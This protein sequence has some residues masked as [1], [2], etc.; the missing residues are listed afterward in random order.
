M[1]RTWGLA[2]AIALS[3]IALQF[4]LHQIPFGGDAWVASLFVLGFAGAIAIGVAMGRFDVAGS[5][6]WLDAPAVG[7]VAAAILSVAIALMQWTWTDS[8]PLP[9]NF[10]ARGDRPYANF[11]QANNFCTALFLGLCALCWLREAGRIGPLG[12]L[13]GS[14]FLLFGMT[15]SGS[16]TG[17]LQMLAA[18]ALLCWAGRR[19]DR[20]LVRVP[21]ALALLVSFIVM[22]LAWPAFNDMLLLSGGRTASDQV[23]AGLRLP[24]WQMV[25]DAISRQ[26]LQG[27][28]WLQNSSA[29]WA[30][31]LDHSHLQR[32][33][34]YSHSLLLDLLIW[35]GLPLGGLIA[36][37]VGWGLYRQSRAINDARA[38]WLF[39]GVLGFFVHALLE[40]PHAYAYLLLPVGVSIGMVHTLCPG[41]ASLRLRPAPLALAWIVMLAAAMV[42]AT[43]YLKV[44]QNY[45][46]ARLESAFGERRIVTPAPDLQVLS[47]LGAF[48]QLIRTEAR[49]GMST[50]E[51]AA[52]HKVVVRYPHPPALLRL[53]LAQGLNDR[54]GDARDTLRRLCAMHL[55]ARCEET[56]ASWHVLQLQHPILQAIELPALPR[57]R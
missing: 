10:L 50:D 44:E 21:H 17:W 52:M 27:Y 16:R 49:P 55:A 26:P 46:T 38:L 37:L 56:R 7:C 43:D 57:A 1:P 29:Q 30:V 36:A 33:I 5:S 45:R 15:M 2:T 47:Q 48:M 32:Y 4:A 34:D 19:T 51:L 31:A 35:A 14:L 18:I 28:G 23:Q 6:H 54:P 11:A 24:I 25:I 3:V 40:L 9:I 12:W 41:Q 20:P 53:A 22:T 8:L 42:T 39:A 13:I